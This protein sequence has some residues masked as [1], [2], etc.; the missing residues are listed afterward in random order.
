[1]RLIQYEHMGCKRLFTYIYI[2][3]SVFVSPQFHV[4]II[5]FLDRSIL[6]MPL[7]FVQR[8][9]IVCVHQELQFTEIPR[10]YYRSTDVLL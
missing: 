3:E 8:Y 9:Q 2:Y 4:A 7:S 10:Q 6:Q 5:C 1:M